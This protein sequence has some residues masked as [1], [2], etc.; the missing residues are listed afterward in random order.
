ML[1]HNVIILRVT[2]HEIIARHGVRVFG[3]KY[4]TSMRSTLFNM[5]SPF[6]KEVSFFLATAVI[7][8]TF[9]VVVVVDAEF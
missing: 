2:R 4:S 8:V 6:C 5:S 7:M 3:V 9:P 1:K